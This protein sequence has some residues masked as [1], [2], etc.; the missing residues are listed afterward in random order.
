L[1]LRVHNPLD[2]YNAIAVDRQASQAPSRFF[3]F[4]ARS[5]RGDT[6]GVD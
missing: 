2:A 5:S 6:D 1:H 3:L 4:K